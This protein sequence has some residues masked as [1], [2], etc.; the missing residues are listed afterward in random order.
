[1]VRAVVDVLPLDVDVDDD[2]DV[3][4]GFIWVGSSFGAAEDDGFTVFRTCLDGT[5]FTDDATDFLF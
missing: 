1:M 5:G 4:L 3:C 2:V